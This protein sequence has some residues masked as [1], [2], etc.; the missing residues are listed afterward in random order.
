MSLKYRKPITVLRYLDLGKKRHT[1]I[2]LYTL[3]YALMYAYNELIN[4]VEGPRW[5]G[6][7]EYT[8]NEFHAGNI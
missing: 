5:T 1:T 8:G 7:M 3:M 4:F 2:I 6:N